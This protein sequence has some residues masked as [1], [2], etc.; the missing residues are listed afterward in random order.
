MLLKF[1]VQARTWPWSW[2]RA[3]STCTTTPRFREALDAALTGGAQQLIVDLTGVSFID[4]SGVDALVGTLRRLQSRGARLD[5]VGSRTNVMRVFKITGLIGIF[6]FY[7][8][9]QEALAAG[10]AGS[11]E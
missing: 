11:T 7:E 1:S 5:V 10:E 8:S 9:R 4:S 2:S 3:R 6:G